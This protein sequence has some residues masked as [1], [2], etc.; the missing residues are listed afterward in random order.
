[1]RVPDSELRMTGPSAGAGI[2]E[3][4][5]LSVQE[6]PALDDGHAQQGTELAGGHSHVNATQLIET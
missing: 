2:G 3:Q 6:P 4:V 5:H 1:M